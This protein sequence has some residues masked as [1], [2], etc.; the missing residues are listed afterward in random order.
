MQSAEVAINDLKNC[1]I[2]NSHLR[3]V[4]K[5]ASRNVPVRATAISSLR[6]VL[7]VTH[8]HWQLAQDTRSEQHAI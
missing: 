5:H 2:L 3:A 7:L 1:S 4:G 6:E 8:G